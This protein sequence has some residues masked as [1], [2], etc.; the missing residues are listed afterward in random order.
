M[1]GFRDSAPPCRLQGRALGLFESFVVLS[2]LLAGWSFDPVA[3][4]TTPG[5]QLVPEVVNP[6]WLPLPGAAWAGWTSPAMIFGG[7]L[8]LLAHI[9]ALVD[10]TRLR[11]QIPERYSLVPA[12]TSRPTTTSVSPDDPTSGKSGPAG[13]GGATVAV[14]AQQPSAGRQPAGMP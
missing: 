13:P 2:C 7:V 8:I 4:W 3:T 9:I 5:L 11:G 12:E 6:L 14:G 10:G 1:M